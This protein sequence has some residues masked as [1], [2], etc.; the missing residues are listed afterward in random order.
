MRK[1]TITVYKAKPQIPDR[2]LLSLKRK[3]FT[4]GLIKGVA[5]KGYAQYIN[6]L[7]KENLNIEFKRLNGIV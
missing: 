1:T 4:L 2:T 3:A 7:S 6:G 5:Y